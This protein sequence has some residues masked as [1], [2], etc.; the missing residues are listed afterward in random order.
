MDIFSF[1]DLLGGLA[2]F[3]YGIHQM[4]DSLQKTA[5]RSLEKLLA[6]M[7]SGKVRGVLLGLIVTAVI[8]S[9]SATI[10]TLIGFVNKGIMRLAQTIPV[11]LGANIG[12]TVTA[13]LLSLTSI[14]GSNFLLEL[15]KPSTFTPV[16]ALV[17]VCLMTF[18]KKNRRQNIGGI[19]IGF[20]VLMFGME[21]MTGA[22]KPLSEIPQFHDLFLRFENP[23]LGLLAGAALTAI[24]QSSSA[25]VGI[26]QALA[27]TGSITYSAAFPI[28]LG[29]NIG[30]CVITM[31][32]S[33][34]AGVQARRV[35]LIH[36]LSKVLSA[37]VFM[38]PFLL[39]RSSLAVMETPSSV[40]GIAF[41]HTGY[42]IAATVAFLPLTAWLEKLACRLIP[43]K[44]RAEAEVLLDERLLAAPTFAISRCRELT[45]RMGGRTVSSVLDSLWLF[46]SYDEETAK[47]IEDAE[48]EVDRLEDALG[49][50][51]VKLNN[52]ALSDRG[53]R[54]VTRILHGIGDLERISDHA[55]NLKQTAE[56]IHEKEI[57]FSDSAQA[58]LSVLFRAVRSVLDLAVSAYDM[59]DLAKA[60]KVEPL[61]EVVDELTKE[62]KSRHIKRL[63]AGICTVE[64]GFVFADLL[65]NCERIADHCSNLAVCVIELN[66][67]EY[68]V[69]GYI[70]ENVRDASF[71]EA[72]RQA[73]LEY[74][75][76]E[77]PVL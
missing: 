29:E 33:I 53:G 25:S 68:N 57:H 77:M 26:L 28:I 34:G 9:S 41:I 22:V 42:N 67:N 19:L 44:A 6:R 56:E 75:L 51:C 36:L 64:T 74:Q 59:N 50:F 30:A 37:V 8:Q 52:L 4:G 46:K 69:H 14:E 10:V 21:M 35:S 12:T 24:I 45:A 1:L 72:I 31:I 62:L 47:Q 61:E 73:A 55:L 76:P 40:I 71:G 49:T 11:I 58:E 16:V 5:G 60:Q 54:E 48:E 18:S 38:I 15:I 70:E 66:R 2:L 43:D 65:T 7:T 23:V 13:W 27:A 39:L 63:R 20:A 32:S 3:I 17:G